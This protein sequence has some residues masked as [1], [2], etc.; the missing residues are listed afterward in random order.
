M[1]KCSGTGVARSVIAQLVYG[2]A[3]GWTIG[4]L[5]FDCRRRLRVSLFTVSRT[6]LGPTQP[7]VQWVPGAPSLGV[8]WPEREVGHSPP[9]SAE[10]KECVE[11]YLQSANTPSR[12]GAQLKHRNNFTFY[13]YS[14]RSRSSNLV[15]MVTDTKRTRWG[16][17]LCFVSRRVSWDFMNVRKQADFFLSTIVW[18]PHNFTAEFST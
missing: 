15:H 12:R 5:G 9:S 2:W 3:M 7:P 10:V 1:L 11:L 13:W 18:H 4:V 14:Y 16:L 8:K 6:V 17:R